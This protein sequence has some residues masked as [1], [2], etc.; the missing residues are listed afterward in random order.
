MSKLLVVTKEY[1]EYYNKELY[2]LWISET[3]NG[4]FYHCSNVKNDLICKI[5]LGESQV[6]LLNNE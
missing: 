3:S 2:I 1:P 6:K 5:Y 4:K